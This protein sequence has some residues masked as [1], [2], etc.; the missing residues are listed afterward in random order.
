MISHSFKTQA[1]GLGSDELQGWLDR[2]Q[3][4]ISAGVN[5]GQI[6]RDRAQAF[7]LELLHR[8]IAAS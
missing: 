1:K 5:V 4:Y 6:D 2:H 3:M 7:D 8:S